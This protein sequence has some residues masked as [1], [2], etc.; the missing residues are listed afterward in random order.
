MFSNDILSTYN[1]VQLILLL[2]SLNWQQFVEIA[3]FYVTYI[4]AYKVAN[5]ENS[6]KYVVNNSKRE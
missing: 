1:V 6:E 5:N 2:I 3:Y 4:K